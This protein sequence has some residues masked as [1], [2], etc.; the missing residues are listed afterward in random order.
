[1]N[2]L[3]VDDDMALLRSLEILLEAQG[4]YVMSFSDPTTACQ[5]VEHGPDIDVFILDYMM[6]EMSGE[7]VLKQVARRLPGNCRTIMI[8]GHSEELASYRILAGLGVHR[9]LPKPLDLE[10][11]SEVIGQQDAGYKK[12]AS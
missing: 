9:V 11:L 2:I 5:Y 1:M 4:H 12:A 10:Q 8:T 6:G 3:V 7:D